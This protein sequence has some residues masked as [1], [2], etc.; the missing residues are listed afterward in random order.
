MSRSVNKITLVGNVGRDPD[1]QETKGGTK[2]AHFS[3]A[4]NR[5][6]PSGSDSEAR[7]DWHRLT[8]WNKLAQFAEEYIKTGDRIYVEGRLEYDSYERDGVS[9]P[10]ADIIVREVVLLSP[11]SAEASGEEM[12]EAA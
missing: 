6:V 9:I 8:L 5:R 3:L 1:I 10:T 4:T 12:E 2:V 7:A 11:K